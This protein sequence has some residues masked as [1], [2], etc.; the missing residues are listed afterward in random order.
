[1]LCVKRSEK[2]VSWGYQKNK[3]IVSCHS[4]PYPQCRTHAAQIAFVGD[5]KQK[6]RN[7][8]GSGRA[9]STPLCCRHICFPYPCAS[10]TGFRSGEYGGRG[11]KRAP[12]SVTSAAHSG[13][14]WPLQLSR[15]KIE[16]RPGKGFKWGTI[17]DP[18]KSKKWS[19]FAV[20]S[21]ISTPSTPFVLSATKAVHL[22]PR[23]KILVS[24][25]RIPR[26]EYPIFLYCVLLSPPDSSKNTK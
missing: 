20:S 22:P 8:R 9:S 21:M 24:V 10:S 12:L 17:S 19:D 11:K 16:C 4:H 5:E 18:R 6:R 1:M 15:I 3:M 23:C 25:S 13:T 26:I 7:S 2:Y 14:R